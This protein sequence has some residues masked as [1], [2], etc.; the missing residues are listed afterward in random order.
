M[1][2]EVTSSTLTLHSDNSII[3]T[4]EGMTTAIKRYL[5]HRARYLPINQSRPNTVN[6]NKFT[7]NRQ[8]INHKFRENFG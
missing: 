1:R 3:V 7:G 4:P 2:I 6:D 5:V 8:Y